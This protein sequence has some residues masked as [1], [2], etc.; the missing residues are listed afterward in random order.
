M[1]EVGI[2]GRVRGFDG[3]GFDLFWGAFGLPW[4]GFGPFENLV[5]RFIGR[6]L[7]NGRSIVCFEVGKRLR[8]RFCGRA[9]MQ[10]RSCSGGIKEWPD[11]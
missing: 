6:A 8:L 2:V 7:F 1:F 9:L 5:C 4:R 10:A 11:I 3:D